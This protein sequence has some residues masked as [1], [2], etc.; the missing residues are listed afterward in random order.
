M[1]TQYIKFLIQENEKLTDIR[2]KSW[3]HDL[4][5]SISNYFKLIFLFSNK[6][7]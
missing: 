3:S 4:T 1:N 6:D 5:K 7:F 2:R